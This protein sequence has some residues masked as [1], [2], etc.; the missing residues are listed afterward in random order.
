MKRFHRLCLGLVSLGLLSFSCKTTSARR[1]DLMAENG[2]RPVEGDFE[3]PGKPETLLIHN[4]KGPWAL[5]KVDKQP[6]KLADINIKMTFPAD[7]PPPP[8]ERFVGSIDGKFLVLVD[9]KLNVI[10]GKTGEIEKT[11]DAPGAIGFA[12]DSKTKAFV[13]TPTEI[14]EYDLD[15]G[16]YGKSVSF[17]AEAWTLSDSQVLA[18]NTEE[19]IAIDKKSFEVSK[20][21]PFADAIARLNEETAAKDKETGRNTKPFALLAPILSV[22]WHKASNRAEVSSSSRTGQIKGGYMIVD[23]SS[24]K[25]LSAASGATFSGSR[26]FLNKTGKYVE[27]Q[28]TA[29]PT[30]STHVMLFTVDK[31]GVKKSFFY[32]TDEK[33]DG[34]K[35][36]RVGDPDVESGHGTAYDLFDVNN[37]LQFNNDQTISAMGSACVTGVCT[38]GKGVILYDLNSDKRLPNLTPDFL[39]FVPRDAFFLMP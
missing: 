13:V 19:L 21:I 23:L 27:L 24:G 39:G 30:S 4:P 18:S 16:K 14:K 26:Y 29:T 17:V 3:L 36:R 35:V 5:V 28:H 22:S 34:T 38:A 9:E 10:D 33:E 6:T 7:A 25:V 1:S 37:N 31:N 32:V 20:K 2:N 15:S 8:I 12:V 11:L